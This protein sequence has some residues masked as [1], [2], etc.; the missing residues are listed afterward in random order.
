MVKVSDRCGHLINLLQV[1]DTLL[2]DWRKDR[3][4]KVLIFTKSVK[5]LDMLDFHLKNHG[6]IKFFM[7]GH[8]PFAHART[9][10][11]FLQLDGSTSQP[12]SKG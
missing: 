9:G 10:Y 5:L 3:L 1:L 2:K 7:K 11:G 4:N 8:A 12:E 6:A